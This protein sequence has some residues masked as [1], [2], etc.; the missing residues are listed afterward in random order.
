[1]EYVSKKTN[2]SGT[3]FYECLINIT[4][5]ILEAC[6]PRKLNRYKQQSQITI[7]LQLPSTRRCS[8]PP[9]L[10]I[11]ALLIWLGQQEEISQ[12][13][14]QLLLN[15]KSL[16]QK[17][18][19]TEDYWEE[20]KNNTNAVCISRF[21]IIL[22]EFGNNGCLNCSTHVGSRRVRVAA[23]PQN[24]FRFGAELSPLWFFNQVSLSK[25]HR[26]PNLVSVTPTPPKK[27]Q[28]N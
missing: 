22:A 1:M 23:Q 9:V 19:E 13:S 27:N 8:K 12:S 3:S 6:L 5:L 2:P 7:C 14:H 4:E 10:A 26:L 16:N 18:T 21:Q 25:K 20:K 17:E 28:K 15:T 11:F 24:L